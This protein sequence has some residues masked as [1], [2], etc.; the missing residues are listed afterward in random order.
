MFVKGTTTRAIGQETESLACHYLLAQG[1]CLLERNFS[2]PQGEIDLIMEDTQSLIFIE[3]RYRRNNTFGSGAETI[4]RSK[5]RKLLAT[6]AR[7]LQRNPQQADRPARFDVIS[8]CMENNRP[9]INW[10]KNAFM[11]SV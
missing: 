10:I 8:I 6:A 7:Y 4:T 9:L 2:V 1:L 3:V 5:Q 11:A